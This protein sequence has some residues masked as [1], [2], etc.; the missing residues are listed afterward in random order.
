MMN[1]F[2]ELSKWLSDA[3]RVSIVGVGNVM[4]GDDGFGVEVVKRLKEIG[5][6]PNVQLIEAGQVPESFLGVMRRFKPTHILFVDAAIQG[7]DPGELRL[8]DPRDELGI[9]VSTHKIPLRLMCEYVEET[10]GSKTLILAIQPKHVGM[11]VGLSDPVRK[12]VQ[13]AAD[14]LHRALGEKLGGVEVVGAEEGEMLDVELEESFL[15]RNLELAEENRRRFKEH[16]VTAIDVLGSIGSG[17]T[18]LIACMVALLKDRYRIGYIAGDLTTTID[19][20]RIARHGVPVIQVNTGRECHLDASLVARALERLN[21]S[22]LDLVFIEN[23][24][25]LICPADFPLGS[26]KRIVV[27]SVTEG[28]YMVVKHPYIFMGSDVAVIN[29]VDLADA[30]GVDVD[31]LERDALRINPKIKVVR[32]DCRRCEGVEGVIEAL[33]L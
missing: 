30:M 19:A 24:G 27:V 18:S 15:R 22:E 10:M 11:E 5:V 7:L 21:L 28:P 25:N 17:K 13:E 20:N 14:T 33:G 29:K 8:L 1:L 26:D 12:G 31:A 4:R 32:T 16:G 3:E 2:E 23:V 9:P 6:P